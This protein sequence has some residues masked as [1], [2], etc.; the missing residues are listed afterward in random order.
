VTWVA[1]AACGSTANIKANTKTEAD[2]RF[3]VRFAWCGGTIS[4]SI[5]RQT[6]LALL[7]KTCG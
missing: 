5:S 1:T 2:H 4:A 6:I 7:R 3:I